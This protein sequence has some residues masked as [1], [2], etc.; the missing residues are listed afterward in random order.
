[1]DRASRGAAKVRTKVFV[2]RVLPVLVAIA[3]SATALVAADRTNAGSTGT[4][5]LPD[6]DQVTPYGVTVTRAR[7]HR[8]TI[9]RLGFSSAVSNVGA[10]PLLIAG[11]RSGVDERQM[12][13]DQ[14]VAR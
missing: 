9:Y 10:G 5:L 13:A 12:V 14:L 6:L 7:A 3:V 1:M 11:H 8:K 4:E 2:L